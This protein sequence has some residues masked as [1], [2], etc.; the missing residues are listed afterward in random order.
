[1]GGKKGAVRDGEMNIQNCFLKTV[2]KSSESVYSEECA[3]S[4]LRG[5]K[6][7]RYLFYIAR[8]DANLSSSKD[9]CFA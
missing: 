9:S 1:M 2:Q 8:V 7:L 3:G 5:K 4:I 6:T